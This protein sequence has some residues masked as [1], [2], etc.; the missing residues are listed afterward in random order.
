MSE[1]TKKKRE[2]RLGFF[3]ECIINKEKKKTITSSPFPKI[4]LTHLIDNNEMLLETKMKA[5]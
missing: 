4:V 1:P 3:Y 5:F 2:A